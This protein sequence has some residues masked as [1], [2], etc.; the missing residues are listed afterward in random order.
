M[1]V[2]KFSGNGSLELTDRKI[3]KSRLVRKKG[4]NINCSDKLYDDSGYRIRCMRS[5]VEQLKNDYA[6]LNSLLKGLKNNTR[7]ISEAD[8]VR[9]RISWIKEEL[10]VFNKLK[11]LN[12]E[13]ILWGEVEQIE[14]DVMNIE[15]HLSGR[16]LPC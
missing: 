10:K 9:Q 16:S 14:N 7:E 1:M 12:I 8:E 4:M 11:M 15:S 5:L 6:E 13:G 3:F 2:F